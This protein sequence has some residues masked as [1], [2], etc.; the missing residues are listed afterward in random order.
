MLV[1]D[2]GSRTA[3][4]AAIAAVVEL[5]KSHGAAELGSNDIPAESRTLLPAA[6]TIVV[7]GSCEQGGSRIA[8]A[9]F[10]EIGTDAQG[11]TRAEV[12]SAFI[13]HAAL[14]ATN[15]LL[16]EEVEEA[17]QHQVDLN[18]QKDDFLAAVSHELRTPLAS[19]LGSVSTLARLHG[20]MKDE[21][22]ERFFNMAT[23]QGKR[24]QRLIEEL[25]LTAAVEQREEYCN[26]EDVDLAEMLT[27]LSDDL[28]E[29]SEGRIESRSLDG[30]RMVRT[31]PHKLRQVLINLIENA[32]K[33]APAGPI[34]VSSR[35][36][37]KAPGMVA[38]TVVDHGPGIAPADR[39]R[40]F[41]RFVQLD[42][43]ATRSRGGT[44]LGLYLCLR[45]ADLLGTDLELTET[46]GG[47][48][49]FTLLLPALAPAAPSSVTH[50]RPDKRMISA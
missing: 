19:M 48:S 20:R 33:Y 38:V 24:L 21:D 23:R 40:V 9:V 26:P 50:D 10:R 6:A 4:D 8:L 46:P 37:S 14:T 30:G 22:R 45:L 34:E 42:Q 39:E 1:D 47:G 31:D 41:E 44:G 29:L 49:T 13:G 36:A 5:V 12:L 7:A 15:A 18:R 32:A 3:S 17:L 16:Y 43:S 28:T 2:R 35:P 11:E 27:E 25:L